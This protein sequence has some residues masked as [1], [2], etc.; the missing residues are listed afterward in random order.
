MNYGLITPFFID[1]GELEPISKPEA[2]V[3]GFEFC[4]FFNLLETHEE[5]FKMVHSENRDRL[6]ETCKLFGRVY[7]IQEHDDWPSIHVFSSKV[8]LEKR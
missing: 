5:F 8:R 2:F 3:L 4:D 7:E 1:K 6:I